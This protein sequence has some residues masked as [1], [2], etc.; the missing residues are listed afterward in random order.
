MRRELVGIISAFCGLAVLPS[1]ARAQIVDAA[2]DVATGD[3]A[4]VQAAPPPVEVGVTALPGG[5]HIGYA[6]VLGKGTVSTAFSAGFGYRS[7]LLASS[8]KMSRGAATA[9]LAYSLTDFLAVGLLLDGRYDKHSGTGFDDDGWVGEPRLHIRAG[10]LRGSLAFGAELTVWTPGKDAP[11]VVPKATSVDARALIS[12]RLGSGL[13]LGANAGF[14]LDNSAESIPE[15]LMTLSTPD[16]ASLGV[17]EWNA[18]VGGV[19]VGYPTGKLTIGFEAEVVA[20]VGGPSVGKPRPSVLLGASVSYRLNDTLT[21]QLYL[22]SNIQENP[23]VTA[24]NTIALIP[25]GPLIAGGLGL[26]ARFGGPGKPT[27]VVGPVTTTCDDPDP[28]KRPAGCPV[29][30]PP[31]KLAAISGQVTDDAGAPLANAKVTITDCDGKVTT[32]TT[33]ADGKY[34]ADQLKPCE[35]TVA[36]ESAGRM[37]QTAKVTLAEGDNTGPTTPLPLLVKPGAFRFAVRSF[38]TGKGVAAE[39]E[40]TP[41]GQ[42]VTSAADGSTELEIAPG[43]YTLTI[44]SPGLKPQTSQYTVT[45]NNVVIVNVD[46]RK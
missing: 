16:Q 36:A 27:T 44:S 3:G 40:I 12:T 31:A 38:S 4:G 8:H 23:T 7:G 19:R 9:A 15:N 17:S 26:Q 6:E 13:R 2:G 10:T 5:D 24:M 39:I 1:T 41:G 28:A 25:Y 45:E 22:A 20:Y 11:S 32:L 37:T 33:G 29:E 21:A 35:V 18:V 14:R 43:T 42:K 34:R 46:L 30:P